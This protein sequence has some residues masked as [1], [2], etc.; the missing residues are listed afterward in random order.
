[1]GTVLSLSILVPK[2]LPP[3]RGV[4]KAPLPKE[5]VVLQLFHFTI[6]NSFWLFFKSE[7]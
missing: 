4:A 3:Y 2:L 5:L 6:E 7:V 1:M